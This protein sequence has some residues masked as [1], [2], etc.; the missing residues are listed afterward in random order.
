MKSN[1]EFGT[2]PVG[3]RFVGGVWSEESVDSSLR[4]EN[5]L[6]A[7]ALVLE[8]STSPDSAKFEEEELEGM[9]FVA[10][11]ATLLELMLMYE[12]DFEV[13]EHSDKLALTFLVFF[14]LL[15]LSFCLLVLLELALV[16]EIAKPVLACF[17]FFGLLTFDLEECLLCFFL[18]LTL[19]GE[20]ISVVDV[21]EEDTDFFFF[22]RVAFVGEFV[23]SM[24]FFVLDCFCFLCLSPTSS[25]ILE[26][27]GFICSVSA[28][29]SVSLSCLLGVRIFFF[30]VC[31]VLVSIEA[32]L[33]CFPLFFLCLGEELLGTSLSGEIESE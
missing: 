22:D 15:F 16:V 25:L 3:G 31:L 20:V 7:M 29:M 9:L 28:V 10:V 2:I 26:K 17:R 5:A 21:E 14:D 30:F 32:V 11:W 13:E 19:L 18:F 12:D 27:F 4:E 24:L 1:E 23:A 6:R 33:L 8:K